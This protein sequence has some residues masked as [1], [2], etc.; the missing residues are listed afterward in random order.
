MPVL[1]IIFITESWDNM[2]FL[3]K[4]FKSHKTEP[5]QQI[6]SPTKTDTPKEL[7]VQKEVDANEQLPQ[8]VKN[9]L[10][11]NPF[12]N[13]YRNESSDNAVYLLFCDYA[14]AEKWIRDSAKPESYFNNYIK[15]LQILTEICKYNVRK[16]SGHPLPKE[17][18]KELKNNYEQNTNRFILRYWKSTLLAANKLKTDKGKQNKINNFFEDISN[19]YSSYLTDE[20]LRFVDSLKSDNQSDVSL[21]KI[22]VT[23]GSY[24]VSTVENIR[25]IPCINSEVM[26]LLQKAATNR[27]A[28]GDLDLAVEC[29]LKSNKISDSLSYEKMHLTEK[30]YLRVIKYAE[31]LNKEL[32]KQ[33]EDKARKEHPEMFPDIILTKECESFKRQIKAMHNLNLSYMQLATSNSCDFCKGYDNKIYSINKTDNTH[34]YVYDLPVFLR[35]G[36]CPKCRIYIGYYMY[37]PELEDLSAP[38]SKNEIEELNRLRNK[39]L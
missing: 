19:K 7:E 15:A 31:L 12:I 32:S 17:Q 24:D 37:C 29:L 22:P 36:R 27:K 13:E 16:T 18:L 14:G 39:T 33:I 10:L 25:A 34:P 4:L 35:T 26:F 6:D 1:H 5:H 20:N 23:C 9:A 2:G 3:D 38:L 8:A 21:E 11:E 28:N 30:Q